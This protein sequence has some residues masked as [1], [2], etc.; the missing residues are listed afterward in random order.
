MKRQIPALALILFIL[1][2]CVS[3]SQD[4]PQGLKERAVGKIT[5]ATELTERAH[6]LLRTQPTEANVIAAVQL[7]AQAGKL[8]EEAWS[9]FNVLGEP[10]V[11]QADI[12]GV[13]RAMNDCVSLIAKCKELLSGAR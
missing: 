10:Y 6:A 9:I 5:T 11:S 1:L 13:L 2:H 4:T 3:W 7:Y 8:F 12:D